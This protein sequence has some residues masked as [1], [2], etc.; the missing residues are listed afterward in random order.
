MENARQHRNWLLVMQTE[1]PPA[2]QFHPRQDVASWLLLGL[3]L[4]YAIF[5]LKLCSI[6]PVWSWRFA[7]MECIVPTTTIPWAMII[8]ALIGIVI[9]ALAPALWRITPPPA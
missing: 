5:L 7:S 3:T 1:T 9:T 6:E 2:K 4:L 8:L